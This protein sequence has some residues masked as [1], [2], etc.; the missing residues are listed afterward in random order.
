M[1]D[2]NELFASAS[3]VLDTAYVEV[4]RHEPQLRRFTRALDD[5]GLPVPAD[6]A[7]FDDQDTVSFAPISAK[8]FRLLLNLFEQIADRL[9]EPICPSP[10]AHDEPLFGI[11]TA[12]SA[13]ETNNTSNSA[14]PDSDD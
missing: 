13:A 12:Q 7:R 9:P 10:S 2:H 11:V 3:E 4:M 8:R 6:W 14:T 1:T 5:L